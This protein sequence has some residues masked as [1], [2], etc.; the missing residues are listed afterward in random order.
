MASF[1]VAQ[2]T[3]PCL[4]AWQKLLLFENGI[5]ANTLGSSL[6]TGALDSSPKTDAPTLGGEDL[7]FL[8]FLRSAKADALSEDGTRAKLF[9]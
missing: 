3:H 6:I 9:A 7:S 1:S 2:P 4:L 5:L 8:M